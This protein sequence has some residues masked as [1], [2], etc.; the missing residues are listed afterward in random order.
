MFLRLCVAQSVE[1]P[2]EVISSEDM[3][4]RVHECNAKLQLLKDESGD[5]NWN[6]NDEMILLGSDVKSLFPSLAG[7]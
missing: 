2:F 5:E 3:L 4:S 6:I 1:V 7:V